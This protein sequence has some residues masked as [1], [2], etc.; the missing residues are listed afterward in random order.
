MNQPFRL[1]MVTVVLLVAMRLAIGWHFCYEG[2]WKI[3][4]ADEF[5]ARPFLAMAKG[6]A[7]PLFY[8][9]IDDLD[10]RRRLKVDEAATANDLVAAWRKV[11]G[12]SQSRYRAA[13]Q[14]A[15]G[16][17]GRQDP[18]AV[19]HAVAELRQAILPVFWEYKG[20]LEEYVRQHEKEMLDYFAAEPR[21]PARKAEQRQPARK[22]EQRQPAKKL[23]TWL[24]EVGAIEKQFLQA[25]QASDY[26]K[27]D[28]DAASAVKRSAA[29]TVPAKD[30][31]G[32]LPA[33]ATMIDDKSW[34]DAQGKK[35]L[36][37]TIRNRAGQDVLFV[38]LGA[39][40]ETFLARWNDLRGSMVP[41]YG[42]TKHQAVEVRD[43]FARYELGL[44][45]YLTIHAEDIDAHFDSLDRFEKEKAAGNDGAAFQQQRAWKRTMELRHEVDGWLAD[46]D[47]MDQ[48]YQDA[49]W[50]ILTDQQQKQGELPLPG[51][52]GDFLD[53]AVTW[54]LTAIGLCLLLGFCTRLAC[55]GGVAFLVSVLLTQPPWPTIFPHAPP[56]VG[57]ALVVDKNF[58]EMVALLVLAST[59][60]GRWGGLDH[61][62]YR[63]IGKPLQARRVR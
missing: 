55:L 19:D 38:G 40:G 47:K 22:A 61:F 32:R 15:Q 24:N 11:L 35:I 4:H 8:A 1:G 28:K 36:H 50:R 43:V 34:T 18:E 60:V 52:R 53:F 58:V 45:Q 29:A 25:L 62:V 17:Q 49:L 16:A 5:S 23:E 37:V 9:M 48:A 10:G 26:V 41:Q 44:R 2:V 3:K 27:K 57:H 46:V 13:L 6:P 14:K 7:A 56:A 30:A 39:R 59:A 51:T 42:L 33:L 21:Q 63:C 20:K 54:G 31:N 12:D